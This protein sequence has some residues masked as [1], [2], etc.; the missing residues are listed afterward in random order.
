MFVWGG[1]FCSRP[2]HS[3]KTLKYFS[4]NV[5]FDWSWRLPYEGLNAASERNIAMKKRLKIVLSKKPPANAVF[6]CKQIPIREKI[7][8]RLFGDTQRIML[9]VPSGRIEEFVVSDIQT[10]Q[11]EG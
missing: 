1:Y 9:I 10:E 8:R 5:R 11:T 4:R 7:L 2:T 3:L 6:S